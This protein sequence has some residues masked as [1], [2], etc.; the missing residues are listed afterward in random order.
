MNDNKMTLLYGDADFQLYG[1]YSPSSEVILHGEVQHWSPAVYK[2]ILAAI[3]GV[4]EA[5]QAPLYAPFVNAKEGRFMEMLGFRPCEKL[6]LGSD[7][8]HYPLYMREE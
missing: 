3:M 6:M 4:Q 1:D 8:I 5:V 2:R 7:G